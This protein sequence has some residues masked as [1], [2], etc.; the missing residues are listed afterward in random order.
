[1]SKFKMSVDKKNVLI[2][3]GAGGLG[4]ETVRTLAREGANVF[5][6]DVNE[7]AGNALAS[8]INQNDQAIGNAE[9]ILC[10]L[11]D[12]NET[13]ECVSKLEKHN[14]GIDILINNAAIYP[15]KDLLEYSM[16]EYRKVQTVNVEAGIVCT[17]V[18]VPSMMKKQWGRIINI[19]SITFY[20]GWAKLMP[21]VVSKASLVGL[22]RALARELGEHG[23]TVN[24]I[25][26]GA[27]PTDAEKIHPDPESYNQHVLDQQSLKRRGHPRDIANTILF[28]S[29]EASSFITGQLL[30]VDGGWVMK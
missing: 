27:F 8:E 16:D 19:S 26:P 14:A 6:L 11:T 30:N 15:S 17:K 2:T 7:E 4:R 22:T 5:F 28:F 18:I 9:F 24:A 21:Y 13:R 20:G 23:I 1:M 3:G 10:D 25:A 29:S 12:L